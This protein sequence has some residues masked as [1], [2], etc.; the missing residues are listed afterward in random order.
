MTLKKLNKIL[1]NL[2]KETTKLY[3]ELDEKTDGKY[4]IGVNGL[5]EIV[6]TDISTMQHIAK[7]EKECQEAMKKLIEGAN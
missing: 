7:G 3:N 6:L 4:K 5:G 2:K 1:N